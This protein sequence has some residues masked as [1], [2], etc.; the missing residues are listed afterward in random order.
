MDDLAVFVF[1]NP[2]PWAVDF[3]EP[4]Q[5]RTE[6]NACWHLPGESERFQYDLKRNG[7]GECNRNGR[8]A[9]S[10][11]YH[12]RDHLCATQYGF[13]YGVSYKRRNA[14]PRGKRDLY[15]DRAEWRQH[16]DANCHNR[17][18]RCGHLEL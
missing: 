2:E 11:C 7:H 18:Q 3:R 13:Y 9:R 16:H 10:H 17:N 14:R 15:P 1:G 5:G 8:I 12:K 6:R 4:G